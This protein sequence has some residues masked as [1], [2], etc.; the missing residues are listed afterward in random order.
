M[1]MHAHIL[2]HTD[3]TMRLSVVYRDKLLRLSVWTRPRLFVYLYSQNLRLHLLLLWL[4]FS[5]MTHWQRDYMDTNSNYCNVATML[6]ID[7]YS[8]CVEKEADN[9]SFANTPEC[10]CIL[11]SVNQSRTIVVAWAFLGKVASYLLFKGHLYFASIIHRG[12]LWTPC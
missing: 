12:V 1:T 7:C 11:M 3:K 6:T 9:I 5:I 8:Y 4:L 10:T 2:C